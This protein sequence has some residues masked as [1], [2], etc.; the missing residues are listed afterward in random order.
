MVLD[1]RPH[2]TVVITQSN[3]LPWRGYFDMLRAADEVILLDSV[4]YTRRDWR[5]RNKI[6]TAGGTVWLTVPVEVKGLYHQAI[7][8]TRV[9]DTAWADGHR[10]AID[11][12]YRRSP[13]HATVFAWIDALLADVAAE[14]M[15][16]RINEVLLRAICARLGL[17][18]RIRRCTDLLAKDA[19]REM[20]PTER[21]V[22][23]AEAAGATRYLSGPAAKAYL[24]P[25]RFE[26]RGIAVDWMSYAGYPDYPQL[27]GEFEPQV[28]IIDLLL[29]TGDDAR[30]YLDRA[31][32]G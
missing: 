18:M 17:T 31:G 22:R 32:T 30:R 26:E 20:D 6:K 29:N 7:D 8:E 16:S 13:H 21:L 11:L 1:A 15:L 28:S 12:A 25:A 14:P 27:W 4:Q 19:M 10:H 2:R 23:L 5:N 24:D 3:Y 9:F